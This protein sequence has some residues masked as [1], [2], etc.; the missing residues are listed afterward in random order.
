[1]PRHILR[2]MSPNPL[3]ATETVQRYFLENRS[4]VL[5]IAA[6]LDRID[7]ALPPLPKTEDFRVTALRQA[8]ATVLEPGPARVERVHAIL[9]DPSLTP[10]ESAAKSQGAFGAVP[11]GC[12]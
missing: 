1:M 6:F 10:L 4:R 2:G 12:C 3:S 11:R 8:L 7:R 5:E 9:S